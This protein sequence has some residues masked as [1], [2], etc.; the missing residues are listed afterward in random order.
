MSNIARRCTVRSIKSRTQIPAHVV[1]GAKEALDAAVQ[2]GK[3]FIDFVQIKSIL[4]QSYGP[5]LI[6]IEAAADPS[7]VISASTLRAAETAYDAA[8]LQRKRFLTI[9]EVKHIHRQSNARYFMSRY[10][11]QICNDALVS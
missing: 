1:K 3:H 10:L 7:R 5:S 11:K 2:K 8:V 9:G 6:S 4:H